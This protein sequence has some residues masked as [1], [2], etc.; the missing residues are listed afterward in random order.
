MIFFCKRGSSIPRCPNNCH[1]DLISYLPF[2]KGFN[3]EAISFLKLHL[4]EYAQT[5]YV[6]DPKDKFYLYFLTAIRSRDVHA[7]YDKLLYWW[8]YVLFFRSD[9]INLVSNKIML[10]YQHARGYIGYAQFDYH[11]FATKAR[12]LIL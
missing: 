2:C 10:E 11:F 9:H 3:R 8:L 5:K 7:F 6:C 4:C 1:P 12:L